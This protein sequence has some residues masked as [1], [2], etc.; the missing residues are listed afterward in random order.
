MTIHNAKHDITIMTPTEKQMTIDALKAYVGRYPSRNKAA[1]SLKGVSPATL[2]AILN[3]KLG[4]VSDEML[5]SIREQVAPAAAACGWQIV[6]TGAFQEIRAA[7]RD[8]QEYK[9]VRWI[10]GDAGCGKTTAA[11]A[12][13]SENREVFTVLCDEDMRKSDFVREIARRVGLK[14]A[15]MRIR[16]TLEAAIGRIQQMDAPLLVFDEGDKLND[17][18]FHYFINLYNHLEGKCGI[19]FMSTSYIEQRIEHGVNSNRKGYNEIYSRIGRRFFTIDPT[20]PM[21]VSAICHAN[22]LTDNRQVSNVIMATEK[23]DFDLRCVKGA[24]H[25]EK[26]LHEAGA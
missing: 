21:D 2:S 26:K 10:V 3:G 18:V 23:E 22:G 25:R 11:A 7:M 12:Y 16:E 20:T 17:N 14:S 13:A 1:A 24:I 15:G 19:V 4:I 9:K 6:E 8:A 5:R